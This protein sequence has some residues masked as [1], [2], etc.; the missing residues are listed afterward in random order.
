MPRTPRRTADTEPSAPKLD[1]QDAAAKNK[2]L[3]DDI[4]LL[5]R[6]LGDVIREQERADTNDMMPPADI[7][8]TT[9]ATQNQRKA[10]STLLDVLMG[11]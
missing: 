4:R 9:G 7:G 2:P 10:N 6:I 8:E 5:G 3:V 1:A 11:N